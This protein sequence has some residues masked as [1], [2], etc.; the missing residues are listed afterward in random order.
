MYA[1]HIDFPAIDPAQQPSLF[2][3]EEPAGNGERF[4]KWLAGF[5]YQKKIPVQIEGDYVLWLSLRYL[6]R[7]SSAVIHLAVSD[8]SG[9]FR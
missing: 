1:Q 2:A 7:R 4:I 6:P 5:R 9:D 8:V 3:L